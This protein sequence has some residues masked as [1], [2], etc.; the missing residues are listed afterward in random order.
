M[1][2]AVYCPRCNKKW[3]ENEKNESTF[4][5][6]CPTDYCLHYVK[7][8]SDKSDSFAKEYYN[9]GHLILAI[10]RTKKY[11]RQI[12]WSLQ[13]DNC[14]IREYNRIELTNKEIINIWKIPYQSFKINRNLNKTDLITLM[15]IQTLSNHKNEKDVKN[16]EKF[17]LSPY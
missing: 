2:R 12:V 13:N 6:I 15:N 17:L 11:A 8:D 9:Y 5:F 14:Y 16:S 3:F 1:D 10:K 4:K 7:D